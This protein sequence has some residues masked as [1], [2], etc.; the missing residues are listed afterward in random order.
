MRG[1]GTSGRDCSATGGAEGS[2]KVGSGGDTGTHDGDSG[3]GVCGSGRRG[4]SGKSGSG[5][6]STLGVCGICGGRGVGGKGAPRRSSLLLD[7][8]SGSDTISPP[9]TC[10]SLE[11]SG[12]G[13]GNAS[14]S[15]LPCSKAGTPGPSDVDGGAK[16]GNGGG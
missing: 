3:G 4:G 15:A 8:S 13:S 5:V 10:A 11:G 6:C 2:G 7:T 9:S 14:S 1:G 12:E 16:G